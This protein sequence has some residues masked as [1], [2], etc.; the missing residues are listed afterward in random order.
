MEPQKL[1]KLIDFRNEL[2]NELEKEKINKFEFIKKNYEYVSK[3]D[4]KPYEN[5]QTVKKG[6][7]SYQYFNSVAKYLFTKAFEL[8]LKDPEKAYNLKQKGF[9][10]YN[11]KN[12]VIKDVLKIIKY[13]NVEAFF[14]NMDSKALDGELFEII[15]KDYDKA[16]FHTKDK[17]ILNRLKKNEV[18]LNKKQ[19][20]VISSYINQKY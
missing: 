11:Y 7:L 9:D 12:N 4:I 16:I 20:S 3:L 13:K 1:N 17:L 5:I 10:N 19:N 15:L 18:F 2:I 6:L 14:I 8:E